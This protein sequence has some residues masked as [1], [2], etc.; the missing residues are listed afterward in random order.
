MGGLVKQL[1]NAIRNGKRGKYA[2]FY[3]GSTFV[4]ELQMKLTAKKKS[5]YGIM[6]DETFVGEKHTMRYKMLTA[7]D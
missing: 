1:W 3:E 2:A 5:L 4:W 6:I 7:I